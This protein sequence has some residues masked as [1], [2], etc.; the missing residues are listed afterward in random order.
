MF[1]WEKANKTDHKGIDEIFVRDL[2]ILDVYKFVS[3]L[4]CGF[5]LQYPRKVSIIGAKVRGCLG[6]LS[7]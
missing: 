2:E 1:R 7:V 5:V 6:A 4:S 3:L